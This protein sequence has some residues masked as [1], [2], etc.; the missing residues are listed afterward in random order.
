MFDNIDAA[1]LGNLLQVKQGNGKIDKLLKKGM[2]SRT[3][4]KKKPYA[5]SPR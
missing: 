5:T 2:P 3:P 1:P 4:K